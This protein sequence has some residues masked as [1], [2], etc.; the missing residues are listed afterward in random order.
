MSLNAG[1]SLLE[2][3]N[4]WN[5]LRSFNRDYISDFFVL[6]FIIITLFIIYRH[7]LFQEI[8]LNYDD[9]QLISA[10]EKVLSQWSN[11]WS[12]FFKG[13]SLDLQPIRDI[14]YSIDLLLRQFWIFY[15]FHFTNI[16]LW[17]GACFFVHKIFSHQSEDRYLSLLMTLLFCSS[18]ISVSSI[19]WIAARKHILSTFFIFWATSI[20][21][22]RHPRALNKNDAISIAML[23]LLACLSQPINVLWPLWFVYYYRPTNSFV[24]IVNNLLTYLLVI[25]LLVL[26]ANYFYYTGE[27]YSKLNILGKFYNQDMHSYYLTFL[28]ISRYCFLNF[29]PFSA[30]PVS[31]NPGSLENLFGFFLIVTFA[32]FFYISREKDK[33]RFI[34]PVIYFFLPVFIVTLKITSIFCSDTYILGASL[35][36]YWALLILLNKLKN[37]NLVYITLMILLSSFLF[38]TL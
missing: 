36:F 9:R 11:Y 32:L 35:G 27:V 12:D 29:F 2:I 20:V 28:A 37:K 25:S 3:R 7:F 15:K 21:I 26:S 8:I 22:R 1:I 14:S 19:A 6:F 38:T 33:A 34:P 31:H 17:T 16:I 18:P 23:Y 13:R 4:S 24:S 30:L 10:S 5:P